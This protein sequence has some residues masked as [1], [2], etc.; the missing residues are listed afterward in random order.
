MFFLILKL[1]KPKNKD[2]LLVIHTY[3]IVKAQYCWIETD[4]SPRVERFELFEW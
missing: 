4:G 1:G 3:T 2:F